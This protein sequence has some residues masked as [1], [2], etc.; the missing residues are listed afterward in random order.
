[1]STQEPTKKQTLILDYIESYIIENEKSPSY[2]EIASGVGL[3]SVASVSEHVDN[4]IEKGYLSKDT[5]AARSL[6]VVKK[7]SYTETKELFKKKMRD[8]NEEEKEILKKAL[9][10]LDLV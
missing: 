1:M 7:P 2:R 8:S 9:K 3:S 5:G 10:I 4:L 6:Q